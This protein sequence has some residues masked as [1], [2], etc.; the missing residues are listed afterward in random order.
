MIVPMKKLS[1]VVMDKYREASLE[2]LREI[3]VV[4]LEGRNVSSDT[5]NQLLARKA[6][7]E[8]AAMLLA[9]YAAKAKAQKLTAPPEHEHHRAADYV[10]AE[11]APFSVEGLEVPPGGKREDL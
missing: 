10:N 1:L 5:L 9:P 4:H 7:I 8:N 2:K 6:N 3:G 11:G